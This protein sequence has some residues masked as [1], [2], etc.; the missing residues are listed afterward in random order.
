MKLD[1][2]LN[3]L[4][5]ERNLS[6]NTIINY[7][8]DL[9]R[10]LVWNNNRDLKGLDHLDARKFLIY[11]KEKNLSRKSIARIISALRT[12]FRY[13]VREKEIL[14]NPFQMVGTPR[15]EKR[16]PNFLSIEEVSRLLSATGETPIGIRD[17]AILEA[18]YAT[19]MRIA[20]LTSL[21]IKDLDL[22]RGEILVFGKGSRERIVVIGSYA[23]TWLK[24]Y[25]ESV[26]PDF[27]AKSST[28]SEKVFL[29]RLGKPLSARTVQR[30]ILKCGKRAGLSKKVTPHIF[31]HTF[32]THL[33]SHGADLRSVQE[34]LGHKSLST[35][36]VYTHLTP[37]R[38]KEVYLKAHPRAQ[39]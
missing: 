35:T 22:A 12:F 36:Q 18:L 4:Q 31:R 19:G 11:L 34:L 7:E 23:I 25:L 16:L 3:Y 21:K 26:R 37:E 24:R 1:Q 14:I 6:S 13:L 5:I 28:P 27:L 8:R 30:M 20:E 29:N 33:L 9:K 10:F 2:F 32:A 38:L 17:R 15:L 39:V